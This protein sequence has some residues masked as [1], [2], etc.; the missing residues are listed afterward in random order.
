MLG[1]TLGATV[2]G[3]MKYGAL[4]FACMS[5]LAVAKE[6]AILLANVLRADIDVSQYLVSEKYD[7]VRAIWDGTTLRPPGSSPNC[8]P[9]RLMVSC[10]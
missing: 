6:P 7:G 9:R 5:L 1:A 2:R 3:W 10:G 8:R 4:G